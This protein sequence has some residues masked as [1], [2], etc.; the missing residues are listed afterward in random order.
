MVAGA[1]CERECEANQLT[2]SS[3]KPTKPKNSCL[4]PVDVTTVP[5]LYVFVDIQMDVD[6]MVDT[7]RLNFPPGEKIRNSHGPEQPTLLCSS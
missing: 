1:L 4:V 6:H 2:L 7:V 5:C 3:P